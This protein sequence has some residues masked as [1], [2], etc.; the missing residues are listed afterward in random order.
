M[1][2]KIAHRLSP[3]C[4]TRPDLNDSFEARPQVPLAEK[5]RVESAVVL[6]NNEPESMNIGVTFLYRNRA[7]S[8]S[9][10]SALRY[11]ESSTLPPAVFRVTYRIFSVEASECKVAP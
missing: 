10:M 6:G 1:I 2:C 5:S 8:L 3:Y 7:I 4:R 11:S 9:A